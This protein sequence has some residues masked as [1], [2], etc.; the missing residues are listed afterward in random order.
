MA[1]PLAGAGQTL[2]NQ[3]LYPANLTNGELYPSG[4]EVSLAP[5][6]QLPI[7]R[8]RYWV[9]LGG[10][11]VLQ[12]Y[13]PV[14]T[15]WRS[16]SSS[17]V[18]PV[19]VD[20]DGFNFR[21]ANLTGCAVAALVT[22]GGSAYVQGSTTITPSAGNSQWIPVVGGRVSTTISITAAGAGY[23][24]PPLVFFPPPP[25]PGV[26]ASAVAVISSGTV[27]SIT[28]LNQGAGY[29]TAPVPA[30]LPNP[31]DPA[32]A[33]GAITSQATATTTLVG[34]GTLSA[35]LC[36]NPGSSFSTV[37]SLTI[38]GAGT[39]AAATIVPMW[40]ITSTSI[41]SGGAAYTTNTALTTIGG[42]PS[43]TPAYTNPETELTGYIPRPAQI[44]IAAATGGTI[45]TIGTIYDGGL[46]VGTPTALVTGAAPTTPATIALTLGSVNATAIMQKAD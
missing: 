44:G 42:V 27:S 11:M 43:A 6:Q 8:G 26:Q 21:V 39:L 22:N 2:I 12:F 45:T 28:V 14:T 19:L 15:T 7:P 10:Y 34:A 3:G 24:V 31:T 9:Q 37:P 16:L 36:A 20:S 41:T 38:A 18:S 40:T 1:G 17:R 5:G 29:A 35:V 46:F 32:L 30:I 4:N 23:T 33:S 13:D 25:S